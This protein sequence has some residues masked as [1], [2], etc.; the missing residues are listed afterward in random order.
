MYGFLKNVS[1]MVKE[2]EIQSIAIFSQK[3]KG[4]TKNGESRTMD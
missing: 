1:G 3:K 2:D 4:K